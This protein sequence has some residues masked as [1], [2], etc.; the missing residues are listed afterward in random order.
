MTEEDED[1]GPQSDFDLCLQSDSEKEDRGA[2]KP[3]TYA[4]A[5]KW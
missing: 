3:S 5:S 2:V 1:L 4:A